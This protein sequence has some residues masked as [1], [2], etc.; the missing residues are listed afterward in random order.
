MTL[1]IAL[2]VASW[3][4]SHAKP[5]DTVDAPRTPGIHQLTWTHAGRTLRYT[6]H[7]PDGITKSRRRHPVVL[8]LHYAGHGAPYYGTGFL[9]NLVAPGLASLD[10]VLVAPDCPGRDWSADGVTPAVLALLDHAIQT[11]SGNPERVVVTGYSMGGMGTWGLAAGHPDRFA[12]A[13]PIAGHPA[14]HAGSV[15]IPVYAIHG[16]LDDRIR[17]GPTEVA[18]RDLQE[19]GVSAQFVLLQNGAHHDVGRYAEP[20]AAAVPWLRR[21]LR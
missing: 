6:V 14:T 21:T 12:A 3:S 2:L 16:A 10:A 13:V 1:S 11:W 5:G 19:R 9:E 15:Q 7:L 4:M 20:L 8:A 18:V 17:Y